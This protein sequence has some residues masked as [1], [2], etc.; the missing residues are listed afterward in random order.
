MFQ[1]DRLVADY[2]RQVADDMIARGHKSYDRAHPYDMSDQE[3]KQF[4][5][6]HD[7]YYP[8]KRRDILTKNIHVDMDDPAG[9]ATEYLKM[10]KQRK[11]LEGENIFLSYSPLAD[12]MA[13]QDYKDQVAA[14][15]RSA[16]PNP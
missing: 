9:V 6:M 12:T 16:S 7:L 1:L 10:I 2:Y 13:V 5:E 15:R 14:Q 11:T 3:R 8:R 4:K